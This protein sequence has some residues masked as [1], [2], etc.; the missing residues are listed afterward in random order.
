MSKYEKELDTSTP[1]Y[2]E[3]I[4]PAARDHRQDDPQQEPP[5]GGKTEDDQK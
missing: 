3:A 1:E 5:K 2:E 4:K